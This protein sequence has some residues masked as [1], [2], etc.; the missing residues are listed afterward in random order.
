MVSL[1][2]DRT[3]SNDDLITLP[4]CASTAM[5]Q[6][7]AS[8]AGS[9]PR[10]ARGRIPAV[11]RP[12]AIRPRSARAKNLAV[13]IDT[14]LRGGELPPRL[15]ELAHALHCGNSIYNCLVGFAFPGA[16]DHIISDCPSYSPA[17]KRTFSH[18]DEDKIQQD[19]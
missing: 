2:V 19:N 5:R 11:T 17:L 10:F 16:V 15:M 12:T 1:D 13:N 14:P 3:F 18:H 6:G 4:T 8:G 7:G 9:S